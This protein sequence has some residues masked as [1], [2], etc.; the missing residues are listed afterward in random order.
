MNI[1]ILDNDPIVAAQQQCNKHVVKMLLESAQ[2]LCTA[3]RLLDGDEIIS[4]E[5]YQPVHPKHPCTLWTMETSTNYEWHHKHWIALCDEYTYRYGKTHLSDQ[6]FRGLLSSLPKNIPT[7][8]LTK[9]RLA[10]GSNPECM[11]DDPVES[12]RKFYMTKQ[13]RFKMIWSKRD[14]PD[15]FEVDKTCMSEVI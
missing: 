7:G 12:Y 10:M 2:M 3:H 6:K 9:F 13:K 4:Q 11:V 14:M 1:F 8:P 5:L 15:W